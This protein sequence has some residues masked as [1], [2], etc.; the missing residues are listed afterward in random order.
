MSA[1]HSECAGF[2]CAACQQR[3]A[4][5]VARTAAGNCSQV[6]Q[7]ECHAFV[8]MIDCH[9]LKS[10]VLHAALHDCATQIGFNA[11]GF[12]RTKRKQMTVNLYD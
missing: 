5:R 11:L 3:P 2:E 12:R 8:T 1:F 9:K 10:R 4:T 6:L 7:I